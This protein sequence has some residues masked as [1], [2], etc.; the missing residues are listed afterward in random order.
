MKALVLDIPRD[1]WQTTTGMN[2]ADVPEPELDEARCPADSNQCI[3]KPL[4]TGFCGSDKSIWF[5]HAFKEMLLDSRDREDQAYRICGHEFLGEI[6]EAGS[7][8]QN[9]YGY[10]PGDIVSTESHIFCGVC[11]QCKIG[12]AHVCSDHLI[13]GISTD[14]CFA[15]QVKLPA[16]ELWRTDLDKIRPEVAAIQEPLGNAVHACSRV[17]LRG[18]TVAV[19]GCG[20]IGLFTILVARA[21]GA[22]MIIGVD[23]GKSNLKMAE[24]L[25]VDATLRVSTDPTKKSG[26][27]PDN[28]IADKIRKQCFGEGVDVAFEMSGSNQALNTAIASTRAGGDIILFG[29]SSGDYTLTD[30]QNIILFG[31]SMHSVVGRKVFQTWYIASNLLMSRGHALQDK[32]YD[33]ILNRGM[34]TVFP[35]KDFDK[36]NFEKAITSHPKIVLKYD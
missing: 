18:K 2:L 30:F 6:V 29:L 17:D 20:T 28:E 15:E 10:K 16:K 22:S 4:Y 31:K 19:F 34:D 3:I 12:D 21:M 23:P 36:K 26:A 8:S 24:E 32:I 13:I 5:R 25:G 14:G 35:F 7:Y 1:E 33:V 9:H 11:H 27:A